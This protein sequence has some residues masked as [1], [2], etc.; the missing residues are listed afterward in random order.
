[1]KTANLEPLKS[2]L[3]A[4]KWGKILG[5]TPVIMTVVATMLAGLSSSEMTKAQYDRSLAAQ[6]QSKAG[7]Q[8]SFFQA[9]RLRS[10]LQQNTL[11]LMA[12]TAPVKPL[13][14]ATLKTALGNSP[15]ATTLDSPAGEQTL[16]ILCDRTL[17]KLPAAAAPN[18]T[19]HA[20]LVALE[21]F[22]PDTEFVTLLARVDENQLEAAL[23]AARDNTVALD[24]LLKPV[25]Q[26]I[27]GIER[28]FNQPE[29]DAS[30]RR[31]FVSAR[32]EYNARRYDAEARLNQAVASLYELQVRKSNISATRHHRRSEIFFYGM[33]A[34]QM[35]VIIST[36]A[37]AA[38]KR[39][40]LWSIAA[41][42]GVVAIA[43]A[44][45]VYLY[46]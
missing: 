10:A 3:P 23:N 26:A 5:A 36:F 11:D 39:S 40:F 17:P 9:K 1:V 38:R 6:L 29:T 33:L 41:G 8:W 22:R 15:A 45:Y 16:A 24:V 4:S 34:A 12:G 35:G 13:D 21:T 14:R 32:I 19:I 18:E 44:I 46:V 25:N 30:L 7:D 27:D 43:F 20:A 2:D 42:A 28:Q 37:M 31:N